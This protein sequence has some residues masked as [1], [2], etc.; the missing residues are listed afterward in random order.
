MQA[1]F[2][3]IPFVVKGL[4]IT[5]LLALAS[6]A[7]ML[8]VGTLLAV[9]GRARSRKLKQFV[10]WY[11]SFFRSVPEL[12]VILLLYFGGSLLI[13]DLYAFFGSN[14]PPI[15]SPFIAGVAALSL[16]YG[17]FAGETLRGAFAGISDGDKDAGKALGMS[18]SLR[19]RRIVWPQVWRLALPG[20]GN[21]FLVLLKDTALVSVI[22]L[23]ELM[24]QTQIVVSLTQ[25]PFTCYLVAAALYLALTSL[26]GAGLRHVERRALRGYA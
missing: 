7:G 26:T 11:T 3:Y 22:S 9:L 4:W 21:L 10:S 2:D 15:I 24:R 6:G 25:L 20:L 18:R 8:I 23:N 14:Q 17:A 16:C 1:F 12:I 13:T 19:L 5:V